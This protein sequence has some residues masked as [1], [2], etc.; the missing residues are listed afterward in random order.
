[1]Q[2]NTHV[3]AELDKC[4]A[5]LTEVEDHDAQILPMATPRFQSQDRSLAHASNKSNP[6]QPGSSAKKRKRTGHGGNDSSNQMVVK[7]KKKYGFLPRS[8]RL[9]HAEDFE[10]NF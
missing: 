5:R 3:Q 8:S 1:M 4:N 2:K 9:F 6:D 10:S 7:G